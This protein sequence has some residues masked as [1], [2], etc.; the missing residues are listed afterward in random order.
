M[1]WE[2][3]GL[4][5]WCL[6]PLVGEPYLFLA[7]CY[8]ANSGKFG[9]SFAHRAR[10][11]PLKC[12]L[13][14][15]ILDFGF[16]IL[17]T[18][19]IHIVKITNTGS[20]PV[21]FY[22]DQN[23][24]KRTGFSTELHRVKNLPYC[25]TET[26]EVRFDPLQA[27]LSIGPA[28][29]LMPIQVVSGPTVNVILRATVTMPGL[30]VSND[31]LDF[32]T[33]QCGHCQVMTIQLHN[34]LDVTCEWVFTDTSIVKEKL[35]KHVPLYL[36]SKL[37]KELKQPSYVFHMLPAC[38]VLN[39]GARMNVQLTFI[40]DEEK[41]YN[42]RLMLTF[43]QSS[44][45]VLI[46]AKG[47]GLEPH[48]DFSTTSLELGPLLPYSPEVEGMV[49]VKNPC[50][51]PVE[52]YSVEFD[53]KYLVEEKVL[54]M[55]KGYSSDNTLIVPPRQPGEK[56][57]FELLEYYK[58]QSQ[59]QEEQEQ[60]KS[61]TLEAIEGENEA[62]EN[63]VDEKVSDQMDKQERLVPPEAA[64]ITS[65][66]DS[67]SR[68]L[69]SPVTE[70][71]K[72]PENEVTE[73]ASEAKGKK[74]ET[75]INL[76]VGELE[77][78]PV[79]MAI[80]RYLGLD[81]S[82]EGCAARNRRG[83]AF[84]VHG[85]PLSGKTN[86]AI[87][88][89][90]YYQA[91]YLVIDAVIREA[92]SSGTTAVA[93]RARDL[94]T[95][96]A[97]E[98]ML[99][100]VEEVSQSVITRYSS[101]GV[102][103]TNVDGT[104]KPTPDGS[105]TSEYK[106]AQ[107]ATNIY[108]KS[109]M[110]TTKSMHLMQKQQNE[111][112]TSQISTIGPVAQQPM[113]ITASMV[114]ETNLM[115]CQLP[116]DVMVEI[117]TER[118]QLN[119]CCRGV[120]FD[121]LESTY[122]PSE[123]Y[124][125]TSLLKAIN[126]RCHIYLINLSQEYSAL[127]AK[128][129]AKQEEEEQRAKEQEKKERIYLQE[130]GEEEYEALSEEARAEFDM[131]RTSLFRKRR[132]K[133]LNEIR[134]RQLQQQK[135]REELER[136]R[137][138]EELKKKSKKAKRDFSFKDD[139]R[140]FQI[141][142]RMSTNISTVRSDGPEGKVTTADHHDLVHADRIE[143]EE[144]PKKRKS[145]FGR[146][147]HAMMDRTDS[148]QEDVSF[149]SPD[150]QLFQRFQKYERSQKK[151]SQ[152]LEFWDRTQG[153]L[154][155]PALEDVQSLGEEHSLERPAPSG[156][157]GKK[158]R[159]EKA[160]K[161]RVEKAEKERAE[162]DRLEREKAEK[163]RLEK[164]RE[165]KSVT[166]PQS[167][168]IAEG[169]GKES[170]E[171]EEALG[172]PQIKL[173]VTD[174]ED[175]YGKI[176][177][178]SGKVPL[179]EEVLDSLGLGPSGPVIPPPALFAVVRY[180]V[181]RRPTSGQKVLSH[182]SLLP[183]P[184]EGKLLFE[185]KKEPEPEPEIVVPVIKEEPQVQHKGKSKKDKTDKGETDRDKRRSGGHKRTRRDSRTSVFVGASSPQSEPD[186]SSGL[187][188]TGKEDLKVVSVVFRHRKKNLKLEEIPVKKYIMST[189]VFQFGSLLCGLTRERYK[190]GQHPENR[191]IIRIVNTSPMVADVSFCFQHDV[192]AVTYLVD[193]PTMTLEA[194]QK[195]VHVST[196]RRK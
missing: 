177:L 9:S 115:S 3:G 97:L 38:G 43:A 185:E 126:N 146:S 186:R 158:D 147:N 180:P 32:G 175:C 65:E 80:G 122:S 79:S 182:F 104:S 69:V 72:E 160:E 52:F 166:S 129:K 132:E 140:R 55:M 159:H 153:T 109:S 87:F 46:M 64:T 195:K 162:K 100:D 105:P 28:E 189:G 136:L 86:T 15:F 74:T 142:A 39:A 188:E 48:L 116:D 92:V 165:E 10:I 123:T 14:E 196:T 103:A 121:G 169:D 81:L 112:A 156:K 118:L 16:V 51:F 137:E 124:T 114:G 21:S 78:N 45:Q 141:S 85:A 31:H 139:T 93:T 5:N 178:D 41:L 191:E 33:V 25:E 91:A 151:I 13:P 157:K 56:L 70:D 152:I 34:H 128:E 57:P 179:A 37:L 110:N 2:I 18:V 96:A 20:L 68:P 36:R 164:S 4:A 30:A 77:V 150:K 73:K 63:E 89:A 61:K 161:E 145:N 134:E 24:L 59:T 130:L 26:F 99:R 40:P 106:A 190:E 88:L 11:E 174:P 172:V 154:M 127:K 6:G 8:F 47:Q 107:T 193:P 125:L 181:E 131:K 62:K 168:V 148:T 184:E 75:V 167:D 117:L 84:I 49:F 155:A 90:K 7:S 113:S 50:S 135:L 53:D 163:E 119:D 27:N 171:K 94:C 138:E 1:D 144:G 54:R 19:K 58:E 176:V 60:A 149:K 173:H 42:H 66:S 67:S 120:V 44:N 183:N 29:A 111:A 133:V 192:K 35:D 194:Y 76:G 101:V 102:G 108:R 98:Q 95:K 12:H 71:K 17:S 83:I 170:A 23:V 22:T 187:E 82:P 143:T